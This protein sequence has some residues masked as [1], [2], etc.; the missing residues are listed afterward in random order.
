[1][2]QLIRA[3][4]CRKSLLARDTRQLAI[5]FDSGIQD[6]TNKQVQ[7]PEVKSIKEPIKAEKALPYEFYVPIECR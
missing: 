1:M 7:Q 2:E 4:K 3:R 5:Q 6:Q